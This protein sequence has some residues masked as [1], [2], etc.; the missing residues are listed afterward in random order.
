MS[1]SLPTL[2]HI[3]VS[4][5]SEKARWALA[6]KGVEHRAQRAAPRRPH[7]GR[8][9][10]DPRRAQDLP[11]PLAR[12]PQHRRLGRDHR[13]PRAPLPRSAPLPGRPRAAP[14]RAR[15]GGRTSTRSSART[16]ATSP[17]TRCARTRTA[18]GRLPNRRRPAAMPGVAARAPTPAPTPACAGSRATRKRPRSTASK[19]VAAFDRIERELGSG[20]YLVGDDFS[21]ADLA[22]ASLLYPIVAP[23]EGPLRARG[24]LQGHKAFREPLVE[25]RLQMGRRDV[26]PPPQARQGRSAA[27]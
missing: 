13:R 16:S 21:V 1:D 14:P 5:F 10:A 12:R 4:H 25:R 3:E 19:I 2:W 9:L 26:R 27:A 15:A 11:D 17:S 18:C 6:Y 20:E 7:R 22:A 8:P 24:S 23:A